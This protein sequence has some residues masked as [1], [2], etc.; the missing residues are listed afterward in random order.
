M[1]NQDKEDR[2][3]GVEILRFLSAFAV[4]CWHYQ[5]FSYTTDKP[6]VITQN[7]P[8]YDLFWPLYH[9]GYYGVQIFWFISGFIFFWK[10]GEAIRNY[11]VS[12]WSFTLARFSRLYPLH[13]ATLV[14][15][16]FLQLQYATDHG[17]YFVYQ[18]NDMWHLLLQ[19]GMASHWGLQ[20][21]YSFNG[22]IWSVS[23]EVLTYV[24]FFLSAR[25]LRATTAPAACAVIA[26]AAI[27]NYAIP[28]V[29][30]VCL[31][32]F[33]IGGLMARLYAAGAQNRRICAR[34]EVVALCAVAA[35]SICAYMGIGANK[36]VYIGMPALIYLCAQHVKS[37]KGWV[38]EGLSTA[39]NVTYSSYLLHFPIQLAIANVY[40]KLGQ[41]I[42]YYQPLFFV[43][44]MAATLLL[45]VLSYRHFEMPAQRILRMRL[46]TTN[47]QLH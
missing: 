8:F 44:F 18:W 13:F 43:V 24:F 6:T 32:C 15:V 34:A 28:S 41:P 35:A 36:T 11:K 39:G 45:S 1:Q 47:V 3:I 16:A 7:Q 5:L 29:F 38:N 40:A 25:Y 19:L 46:A 14:I 10:Y 4:L 31:M 30:L 23:V 9:H 26:M 17:F 20:S 21:G 42:P 12:A 33:Y 37:S 22:P 27:V 2:L